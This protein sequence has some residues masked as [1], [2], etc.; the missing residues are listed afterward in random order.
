VRYLFLYN[1][2]PT[3]LNDPATESAGGTTSN[4]VLDVSRKPGAIAYAPLG[5]VT[6][7]VQM[8]AIDGVPPNVENVLSEAYPFWSYARIYTKGPAGG[9]TRVFIDYIL[10]ANVQN[11][12]IPQFGF[13]PV[14]TMADRPDNN[15]V[16]PRPGQP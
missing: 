3:R 6:P 5:M 12:L 16:V 13:I 7:A 14:R 8:V 15:P 2:M 4:P 9:L 11:T 1:F 10:S